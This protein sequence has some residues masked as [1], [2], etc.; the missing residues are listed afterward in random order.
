[1]S[2]G[3]FI[4]SVVLSVGLGAATI[5]RPR[6][7]DRLGAARDF[8]FRRAARRALLKIG[9]LPLGVLQAGFGG[10][11]PFDDKGIAVFDEPFEVLPF[12]HAD[13][14]GDG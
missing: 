9:W 7:A 5:A 3:A 4:F 2:F 12:L 6:S 13:R 11:N 14:I 10:F 8:G 1:M